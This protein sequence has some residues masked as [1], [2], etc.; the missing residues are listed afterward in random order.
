MKNN[1]RI[2]NLEI[3]KHTVEQ[4]LRRMNGELSTSRRMGCSAVKLIHGYGSSGQG[5][6]LRISARQAL[7]GMKKKGQIKD[8]LPGE[9]F[10]IFET[11]TLSAFSVAP[12]LR[13]DPDLERYNNGITIVIL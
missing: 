4:G 7:E 11:A 3:G 1:V 8:Y 5:G 9:T 2:V 12:A 10:T 6:K 13:K